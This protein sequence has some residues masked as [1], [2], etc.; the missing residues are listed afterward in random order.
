M[1]KPPPILGGGEEHCHPVD[2]KVRI[3]LG[4]IRVGGG[5]GISGGL[6]EC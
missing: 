5:D 2:V 4:M 1:K 6:Y 3:P